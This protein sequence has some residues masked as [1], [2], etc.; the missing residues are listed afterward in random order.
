M[1]WILTIVII[2]VSSISDESYGALRTFIW[3]DADFCQYEVKFDPRRYEGRRVINTLNFIFRGDL[4]DAPS[5]QTYISLGETGLLKYTEACEQQ[6]KKLADIP[7]VNLSG[8]ES[9]RNRKIDNLS[10]ECQF[11][12]ISFR[13]S[14]GNF[15]A[16]REY[17]P[18]VGRCSRFEDALE[19]KID[20]TT[21]WRE[22]VQS[23]CAK[24]FS[25]EA[26]RAA[27][28]EKEN[29]PDAGE[30]IRRDVFGYGWNNC[31]VEYLRQNNNTK[32]MEMFRA[33][34]D[35]E[36]RSRFPINKRQCEE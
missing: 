6:A 8:I 1:R 22:V 18:A 30:Q 9:Y 29:R 10:N 20:I 25:P 15:A 19:G 13:G 7:L 27:W 23:T 35:A 21:V 2:L 11:G 17:G 33:R 3:R 16:L 5:Y 31:S 14:L 32:E 36:L 4:F 24:H 12:V 26:C 28:F 34:L